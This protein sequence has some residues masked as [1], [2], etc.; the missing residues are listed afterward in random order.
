MIET[1]LDNH[2]LVHNVT[3]LMDIGPVDV[4]DL[5]QMYEDNVTNRLVHRWINSAKE[6]P[7]EYKDMW[8]VPL[9]RYQKNLYTKT[10]FRSSS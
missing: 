4:L 8:H 6:A 3:V 9:S 7:L 1:A 10:N 2:Q 5:E